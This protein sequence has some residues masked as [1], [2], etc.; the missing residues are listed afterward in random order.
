MITRE[1]FKRAAIDVFNRVFSDKDDRDMAICQTAIAAIALA[2]F[3]SVF[4]LF[5]V[6]NNVW[7]SLVG[8]TAI[9]CGSFRPAHRWMEWACAQPMP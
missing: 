5:A 8:T 1:F 3:G 7:L 4:P 2:T 9:M 6:T